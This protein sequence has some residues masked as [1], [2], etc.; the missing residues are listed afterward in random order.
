MGMG[1]SDG[2]FEASKMIFDTSKKVFEASATL[3]DASKERFETTN[4]LSELSDKR[5]DASEARFEVSDGTFELSNKVFETWKGTSETSKAR[6]E[7]AKRVFAVGKIRCKATA[8]VGAANIVTRQDAMAN[9][10]TP[11]LTYDSGALYDDLTPLPN[12]TKK[13]MAKVKFTLSGVPDGD[14]VQTCTSL[15]TALTG[16]ANFPNPPVTLAAFG[17]LITTAQ[18]KLTAA[19]TTAQ[20]AMQ[21]TTDKDNAIGAMAAAANQLAAYVDLMANGDESKILSAGLSVRAARQPQSV[22]DAVQNLSLTAGDNSG[23]LD[24]QWDPPGNAKSYEVQTSADPFSDATW[25]PADTVTNSKV[26]LLGLPSAAK[27]WVRVRG[28]N[29]AGKGA[30]SDPAV[31][32]VP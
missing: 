31:K 26:A 15:K 19:D 4:G 17:T 6:F 5:F 21:A 30:W 23:E 10:D 11:G 8:G 12:T 14:A 7:A 24:A 18:T 25:K 22:P 9:Y 27:I 28:I 20:A 2:V 32:V 3:F 1:V 13:H 29:S 16:N